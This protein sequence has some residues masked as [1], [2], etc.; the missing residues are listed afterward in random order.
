MNDESPINVPSILAYVTCV[1]LK[2]FAETLAAITLEL[3]TT[4]G[5][6]NVPDA[7]VNDESPIN[8]PSILAYVTCV[9]LKLF[10]ETL[11]AVTLVL[12]TTLLADNV[13]DA[14]VNDE[15]PINV[16]SILA[17]T[18]SVLLK[19]FALKVLPKMSP[20][21]VILTVVNVSV[22]A[23]YDRFEL[24]VTAPPISDVYSNAPIVFKLVTVKL[25]IVAVF[26]IFALATFNVS[27]LNDTF[28][29]TKLPPTSVVNN[30]PLLYFVVM[31]PVIF[32]SPVA[33]FDAL[34]TPL[35]YVS[36]LSPSIFPSASLM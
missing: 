27:L 26:V 29:S 13:P 6:D 11:A 21:A 19:L 17:K 36:E 23:L 25:P 2:L 3:A 8:V 12:A 1:L 7:Y 18:T 22:V 15:S 20:D 33:R 34:S 4:L 5:A 31:L 14:Y 28:D 10:A 9:L 35:I 32:A 30:L 16:P 24:S